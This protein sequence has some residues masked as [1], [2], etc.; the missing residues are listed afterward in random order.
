MGRLKTVGVIGAGVAGL[1]A[2][3]LLSR[4]G[5]EVKL[6]E[7]NDK[8][9]GLC[10]TS[11]VGGYTF[12]DGAVYLAFPGIL[13]HVFERLGFDRRSVLPLRKIAS[14]QTTLPDG[15]VVSIG[16]N[17]KVSVNKCDGKLDTV[18][19]QSEVDNMRKKWE[20][21]LRIYEDDIFIHPFSLPRLVPKILPHFHKL[22]GTVASEISSLFTEEAVR[23]AMAGALFY[24]GLPPQKLPVILILGL[25]A[26]LS[27]GFYLP[28]GGMGKITETLGHC[29]KDNGGEIFLNSRVNKILLKNGRVYGLQTEAQGLVEVDAVLSTVSGMI[30][31]SLLRD[32]E[33]LPTEVSRK[34]KQAPLSNNMLSI[35]LGLSNVIDGCSHSNSTLPM[36]NEQSRLFMPE[37]DEVKWFVY[38]VPTVTMPELAPKGRSIIEMFPAIKEGIPADAWDNQKTAKVVESA[39]KTLRQEHKIDIAVKRV[40][41]PK[42]F[43]D[44]LHLYKGAIY[45]LSPAADIRALFPHASP[46]YGLYQAGQTTYPGCS[47]ALAAMSGIFAAETLLNMENI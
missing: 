33:C 18:R 32:P 21:V 39:I 42:Y 35:Q 2:G 3:G 43:Q 12:N 4:Q 15:T 19:L 14:H 20:P 30:T 25:T 45:G 31:F 1:S 11:K 17:F 47:V 38:F 36:M 23:A 46:I 28:E 5:V 37:G 16:H 27:E 10:A 40:L 9:G 29:L 6:F 7:A 24:L 34:V 44:R 8:P 22:Q 26:I 13:D 41:S